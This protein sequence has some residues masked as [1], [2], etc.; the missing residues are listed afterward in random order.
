MEVTTCCPWPCRLLEALGLSRG[1]T[2]VVRE[3]GVLVEQGALV[4]T[5]TPSTTR[6]SGCCWEWWCWMVGVER[7]VL[8]EEDEVEAGIGI[9]KFKTF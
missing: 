2:E 6:P 3:E 7:G 1:L 9:F 8:E 5:I 4:L